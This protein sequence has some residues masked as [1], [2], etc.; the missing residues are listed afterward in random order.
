MA[1]I[2]I[3][4]DGLQNDISSMRSYISELDSLSARTQALL[5]RIG[6]SWEGDASTAYLTAMQQRLDKA[7]QMKKVLEEFLSYMETAKSKFESRDQSSA[8]SIKGC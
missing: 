2:R 3:N 4:T 6:D 8:S 7:Q 1:S 5:S